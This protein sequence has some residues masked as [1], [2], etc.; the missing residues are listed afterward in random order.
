MKTPVNHFITLQPA[1]LPMTLSHSYT[2]YHVLRRCLVILVHFLLGDLSGYRAFVKDLNTE[3]LI[4][5]KMC[6]NLL[7]W[8][9]ER[10]SCSTLRQ[11]DV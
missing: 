6:I 8:E 3:L 5:Q 1:M 2:S 11:D 7:D 10:S 9:E 4:C